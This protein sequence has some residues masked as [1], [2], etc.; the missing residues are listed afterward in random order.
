M[1]NFG[2]R[3]WENEN[4]FCKSPTWSSAVVVDLFT[5]NYQELK[6][7]QCWLILSI[8]IYRPRIWRKDQ[9]LKNGVRSE[10]DFVQMKSNFI[11]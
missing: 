11:K 1:R 7:V 6:S 8:L 9:D 5:L 10:L 2:A 3:F 4:E